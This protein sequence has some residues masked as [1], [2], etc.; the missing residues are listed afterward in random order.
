MLYPEGNP[1]GVAHDPAFVIKSFQ[2]LEA[3][4]GWVPGEAMGPLAADLKAPKAGKVDPGEFRTPDEQARLLRPLV[5]RGFQV[6][7]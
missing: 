2:N 5:G 3:K 6:W 1:T 7:K 4:H